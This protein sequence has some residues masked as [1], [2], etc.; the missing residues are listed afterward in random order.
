MEANELRIGN[1]VWDDYSGEM[2]VVGL[3]VAFNTFNNTESVYLKKDLNLPSGLYDLKNVHP[4]PLTTEWFLRLGFEQKAGNEFVKDIFVY[5]FTQRDLII[6]GYTADYN[7]VL[8]YPNYVHELQNLYF[9][10]TGE[11]LTLKTT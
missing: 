2:I 4:I 6:N 11:E 7:G 5:R 3:N 10:F 8:A 9:I 1:L